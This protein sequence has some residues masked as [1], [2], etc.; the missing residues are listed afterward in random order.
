MYLPV[1][2]ERNRPWPVVPIIRLCLSH[3][4]VKGQMWTL[5]STLTSHGVRSP[6]WSSTPLRFRFAESWVNSHYP[7]GRRHLGS[8]AFYLEGWAEPGRE[9]ASKMSLSYLSSIPTLDY[10]VP[11]ATYSMEAVMCKYGDCL[12]LPNRMDPEGKQLSGWEYRFWSQI[13][14]VWNLVLPC[15]ICS[16]R[17]VIEPLSLLV[18]QVRDIW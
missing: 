9:K 10:L 15:G 8:H 5:L 1:V 11:L 7:L 6:I 16:V 13:A 17:I 4:P 14:Q 3:T 2:V 12:C 18:P